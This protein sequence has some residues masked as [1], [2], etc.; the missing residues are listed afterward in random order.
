PT[1]SSGPDL[2]AAPAFASRWPR[3]AGSSRRERAL[4]Q[5]ERLREMEEQS[6]GE[7][8]PVRSRADLQTLLERRRSGT[9]PV[10]A[11]LALEGSQALEGK[12][13]AIDALYDAGFRMMAP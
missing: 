1:R 3:R 13:A 4:Y 11:L 7:L 9:H 2:V 12:L 8:V 10:G 5:A 6:Q